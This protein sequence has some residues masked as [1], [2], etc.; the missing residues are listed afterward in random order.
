MNNKLPTIKQE[1][2]LVLGKLN[3]LTFAGHTNPIN[4][5]A[6][7][8]D[9]KTILSGSGDTTIKLWNSETGEVI[10]TFEGHTDS[11][12]T[13]AFNPDGKTILSGSYDTTIKLWDNEI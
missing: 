9:G 10:R 7:S 13:V 12:N 5:V 6:F 11:V 4:T 2:Q 3:S 8:P 1:S